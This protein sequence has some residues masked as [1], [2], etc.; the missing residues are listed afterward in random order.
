[1]ADAADIQKRFAIGLR[2]SPT[3]DTDIDR[4]MDADDMPKDEL[5]ALAVDLARRV[6]ELNKLNRNLSKRLG[7][8]WVAMAGLADIATIVDSGGDIAEI[9]TVLGRVVQKMRLMDQIEEIFTEE[10]PNAN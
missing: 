8:D 6:D 1:M 2:R 10:G 7:S 3:P 4:L 9:R 5:M